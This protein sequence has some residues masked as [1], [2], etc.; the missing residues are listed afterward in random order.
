M[1]WFR[2][3]K[4][5]FARFSYLAVQVF[6]AVMLLL[7]LWETG[8]HHWKRTFSTESQSSLQH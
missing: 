7:A 5:P 3:S 2:P 6:L 4:D 1:D 8:V